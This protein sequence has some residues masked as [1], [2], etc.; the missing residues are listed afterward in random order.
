[1]GKRGGGQARVSID[2]SPIHE[3]LHCV[4]SYDHVV[5]HACSLLVQGPEGLSFLLFIDLD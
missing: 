1:M 3:T 2:C 5:N 4:I